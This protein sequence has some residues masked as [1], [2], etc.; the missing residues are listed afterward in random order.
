MSCWKITFCSRTWRRPLFVS[1]RARFFFWRYFVFFT[2]FN[3]CLERN[4]IIYQQMKAKH[5]HRTLAQRV[6]STTK[7]ISVDYLLTECEVG[8]GKYLPEDR[9]TSKDTELQK[10]QAELFDKS[11]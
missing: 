11:P 8:V 2:K 9:V 7:Q 6:Y 5:L 1:E 4:K 10:F 3:G